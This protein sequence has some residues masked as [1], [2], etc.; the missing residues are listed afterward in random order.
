M[1]L[2]SIC[3]WISLYFEVYIVLDMCSKLAGSIDRHLNFVAFN[4]WLM[5]N[6]FKKIL[7]IVIIKNDG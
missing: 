3:L 5:S 4:V 2:N 6:L 1:C 7:G